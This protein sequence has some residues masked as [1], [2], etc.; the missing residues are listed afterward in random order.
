MAQDYEKMSSVEFGMSLLGREQKTFEQERKRREK[1]DRKKALAKFV[2]SGLSSMVKEKFNAFE[3][4]E[5]YKKIKL[6][7]ILNGQ[8]GYN[9]YN[10]IIT[11]NYGGDSLAFWENFYRT[12]LT[13][14]MGE[15]GIY[16][17]YQL[18]G[19][20]QA[21]IYKE[22]R[23]LATNKNQQWLQLQKEYADVPKTQAELDERWDEYVSSRVP[24]NLFNFGMRGLK[25]LFSGKTKED[26]EAEGQ[27]EFDERFK[28]FKELEV[29]QQGFKKYQNSENFITMFDKLKE[30]Y[31]A[32]GNELGFMTLREGSP[33][34]KTFI[35]PVEGGYA[36]K[37]YLTVNVLNDKGQL[38][39]RK[40][41][42]GISGFE[43]I[44]R[45]E[46]KTENY[47][48]AADALEIYSNVNKDF[49]DIISANR[50]GDKNQISRGILQ[51]VLEVSDFFQ[52]RGITVNEADN[53]AAEYVLETRAFNDN[54]PINTNITSFDLYSREELEGDEAT[55]NKALIQLPRFLKE[56]DS[57]RYGGE[58]KRD[59]IKEFYQ[60]M[61]DMSNLNEDQKLE[62]QNQINNIF[63][64]DVDIEKLTPVSSATE[65]V[66]VEPVEM[67]EDEKEVENIYNSIV[68]KGAAGIR[69]VDFSDYI[70]KI[71]LSKLSGEELDAL[72]NISKGDI[73]EK[74]NIPENIDLS[75][76]AIERNT[77]REAIEDELK[78]REKKEGVSYIGAYYYGE[79]GRRAGLIESDNVYANFW[80]PLEQLIL[81]S[82]S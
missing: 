75:R 1:Q 15:G 12:N 22:A 6:N 31:E 27:A 72:Y 63:H 54:N 32:E 2:T 56:A 38:E 4:K 59:E 21:Y 44:E 3:Q 64:P 29:A 49:K 68:K 50:V 30:A 5:N 70:P 39:V 65:Q 35:E 24:T 73:K 82:A 14:Q 69:Y 37:E 26:I 71:N 67:P 10:K 42:I 52:Q 51:E 18:T 28:E 48:R 74:L 36:K 46:Y 16:S 58:N 25:N 7:D 60:N 8:Q 45:K 79:G 77:F 66:V 11:D 61:I 34:I 76:T 17:N 9:E 20:A 33:Q 53:L 23:K 19:P 41:E 78:K 62:Y 81:K 57:L 55:I 43:A 40:R 47:N 13:A 80:N